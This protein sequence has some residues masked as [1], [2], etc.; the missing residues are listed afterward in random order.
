MSRVLAAIA[1]RRIGLLALAASLAAFV[2]I[3]PV[4]AETMTIVCKETGG[5]THYFDVDLDRDTI[6]P[7]STGK[8]WPAQISNQRIAWS[9][10]SSFN[11]TI[12]RLTGQWWSSG[13]L[14]GNC[15]RFEGKPAL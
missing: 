3:A 11:L 2:H 7:R 6:T 4:W 5:Y 10:S 14:L 15:Q 8:V 1:V 13:D 9:Y 12:D